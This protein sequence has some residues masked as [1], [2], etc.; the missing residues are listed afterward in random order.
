[1]YGE[2]EF[3][4]TRIETAY[5]LPYW[6]KQNDQNGHFNKNTLSQNNQNSPKCFLLYM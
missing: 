1:M 2:C 6:N 4:M 3:K 5:V